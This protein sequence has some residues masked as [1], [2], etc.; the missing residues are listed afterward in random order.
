MKTLDFDHERDLWDQG[1]KYVCG[2]DEVGRGAFCGP[3]VVA[4]V[5]FSSDVVLPDDLLIHDSKKLTQNRRER[6]YVWIVDNCLFFGIGQVES[7]Y[8]NEFGMTNSLYKARQ[9]AFENATKSLFTAKESAVIEHVFMDGR[10]RF[11]FASLPIESQTH[12]VGGDGIIASV[13]CASIMAKVYR[14]ALMHSYAHYP[15]YSVYG[16]S[17]NKGYGTKD[18]I[19]AIKYHGPSEFHRK[20]FIRNY[21]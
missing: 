7:N 14:D 20:E 2:I 16:W 19:K 6:A 18:H 9:I 12:L 21:I 5:G 4:C 10:D 15:R 11:F 8:I 3:L 17:K 1:T 13:A